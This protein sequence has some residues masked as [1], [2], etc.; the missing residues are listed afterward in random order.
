MVSVIILNYNG[1]NYIEDCLISIFSND[2]PNFEVIVVDNASTDNSIKILEKLSRLNPRLKVIQGSKNVGFSIGNN[3]GFRYAK[4]EYVIFLNND[5]MVERNFIGELV[6][7]A[8]SDDMIGSVGCKIVQF[9][10]TIR[11]GPKYTYKGFIVHAT[12]PKTYDMFTV[13]L[14]NCGCAVLYRKT[15]LDKIGVF[16]PLFLSDWEDH[17]L[18]YRLNLSGFKSVYTPKTVVLHKGGQMNKTRYMRV[19][20]NTLFT[21]LRNYEIKNIVLRFPLFILLSVAKHI[22]QLIVKRRRDEC[23]AFFQG[24]LMFLKEIKLCRISRRKVQ[25]L[26][27]VSDDHIFKV[28]QIPEY[29]SILRI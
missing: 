18:G 22:F 17:D 23:F 21:Y 8:E 24:L 19:I 5:T 15:V 29:T 4:G 6:R 13:N 14:A 9:D 7:I 28:T 16:D 26:R 20:R 12:S 25:T 1:E 27:T 3:I 11:Y 10:G 2:Y